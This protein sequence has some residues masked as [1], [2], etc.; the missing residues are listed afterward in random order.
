MTQSHLLFIYWN[1][2]LE[3]FWL[4]EFFYEDLGSWGFF[5][6]GGFFITLALWVRC[7]LGTLA[8]L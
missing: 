6:L 1:K 3:H 4:A 5:Y 7:R 2:V 8:F